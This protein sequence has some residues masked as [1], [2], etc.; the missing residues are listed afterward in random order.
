MWQNSLD[1]DESQDLSEKTLIL[2]WNKWQEVKTLKLFCDSKKA[3][4]KWEDNINLI[5]FPYL[6]RNTMSCKIF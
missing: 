1:Y 3:G 5:Y 4:I 2:N 6:W